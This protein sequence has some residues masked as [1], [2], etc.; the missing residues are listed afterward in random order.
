[1]LSKLAVFPMLSKLAVLEL[2]MMHHVGTMRI[3]GAMTEMVSAM[4]MTMTE[5]VSA[6]CSCSPSY[7]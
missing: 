2:S 7:K 1:M 4:I 3:V 5:M 6:I